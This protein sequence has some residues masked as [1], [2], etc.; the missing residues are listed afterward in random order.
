MLDESLFEQEVFVFL[1]L[2]AFCRCVARLKMG[3][4]VVCSTD[5][6][7][8]LHLLR[9]IHLNLLLRGI[10][11][12]EYFLILLCTLQKFTR[13]FKFFKLESFIRRDNLIDPSCFTLLPFD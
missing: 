11:H 8:L 9:M 10:F 3:L 4:L 7:L 13:I 12:F 2:S 6:H 1:P 5:A